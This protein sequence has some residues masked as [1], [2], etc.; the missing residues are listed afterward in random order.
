MHY[1]RHG[2]SAVNL[3]TISGINVVGT[4]IKFYTN[5][6]FS[7]DFKYE[8]HEYAKQAFNKLMEHIDGIS[9]KGA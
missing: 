1:I 3:E 8:N 4:L 2:Q 7:I 6:N 9:S 5:A